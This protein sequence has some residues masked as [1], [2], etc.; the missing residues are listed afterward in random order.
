MHIG[1]N[2]LSIHNIMWYVKTSMLFI[3]YNV[4]STSTKQDIGTYI[5][6]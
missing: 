6:Y 3:N 5:N 2:T 4:A 1:V